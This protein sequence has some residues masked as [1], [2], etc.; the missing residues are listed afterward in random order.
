MKI[1]GYKYTAKYLKNPQV[2]VHLFFPLYLISHLIPKKAHLLY[3]LPSM[4]FSGFGFI[5]LFFL[6]QN[7][8]DFKG[9]CFHVLHPQ[10]HDHSSW[11]WG[12]GAKEVVIFSE[13]WRSLRN[14]MKIPSFRSWTKENNPS[15]PRKLLTEFLNCIRLWLKKHLSRETQHE[16]SDRT[17]VRG[18]PLDV[19]G[20]WDQKEGVIGKKK[21]PK[22]PNKP[23][24][25]APTNLTPAAKPQCKSC[26]WPQGVKQAVDFGIILYVQKD[27]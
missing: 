25:Q 10:D 15:G 2:S 5:L 9:L 21:Q 8:S 12:Q 19:P 26:S 7:M 17:A 22:T 18:R 3:G 1:C 23:P 13:P 6:L 24:K 16:L 20:E 27:E 4:A 14:Q 11:S